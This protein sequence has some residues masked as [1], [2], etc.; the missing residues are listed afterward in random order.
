MKLS[1]AN[2]AASSQ[3]L[4]MASLILPH[5]HLLLLEETMR[6][7]GGHEVGSFPASR[8]HSWLQILDANTE[9][10]RHFDVFGCEGSSHQT[11]KLTHRK[12]ILEHSSKP[13]NHLFLQKAQQSSHL[14]KWSS[15]LSYI[16]W[17]FFFPWTNQ[18][19]VEHTTH[20]SR[21][22][23]KSYYAHSIL[24]MSSLKWTVF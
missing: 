11:T 21:Q 5:F 14:P 12:A 18:Q 19:K 24:L 7:M 10:V 3:E 20:S 15:A 17:A 6:S 2:V 4:W 13:S 8:H 16:K 23:K 1:Q 9:D 22:L